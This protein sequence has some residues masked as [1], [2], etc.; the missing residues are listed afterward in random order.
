MT[1]YCSLGAF[2]SALKSLN[3]V[4]QLK[5]RFVGAKLREQTLSQMVLNGLKF[6]TITFFIKSENLAA[7]DVI[8]HIVGRVHR[9]RLDD[10]YS[11]Y[12]L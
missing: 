6:K 9:L 4:R 8:S 3:A 2:L 11:L 12:A 1:Y 7:S 10:N 5:L